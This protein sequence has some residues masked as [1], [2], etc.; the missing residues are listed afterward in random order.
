MVDSA[1]Q[2]KIGLALSG[3]SSRAAFYIGFLESLEEQG[4]RVHSISACSSATIVAAA[5]ATGRLSALKE[6]V[7]SLNKDVVFSLIEPSSTSSSLYRLDRFELWLHDFI[8]GKT[9]ADV[10][11]KLSFLTTD[12]TTKE[13]VPM[14]M[15]SIAKAVRASCTLPGVFEP[16]MWG[17]KRLVDG[18]LLSIVPGPQVRELG[19]DVVLGINL[20][21]SGKLFNS[22]QVATIRAL[23]YMR[24]LFRMSGGELAWRTTT[25]F[26]SSLSI[27]SL[28]QQAD[29][30][31]DQLKQQ[32]AFSVLQQAINLVLDTRHWQEQQRLQQFDCD[33]LI[34]PQGAAVPPLKRSLYLHLTD[35]SKMRDLYQ[36][37]R[38]HAEQYGP[39]LRHWPSSE[40]T[41][42]EQAAH[43]NA[44]AAI[45]I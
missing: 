15:G 12:L 37:G 18:G 19:A 23:N 16:V 3:A 8:G 34:R 6:I 26:L 7:L 30:F 22:T 35:F 1:S 41:V 5:Y 20:R 36:S 32:H 28:L 2:P 21:H 14:S 38:E 31:S 42:A 27:S 44:L 10:S 4:I 29:G 11:T 43:D 13:L 25:K 33:I 40:A 9:F 17:H 24:Q 45:T 39:I